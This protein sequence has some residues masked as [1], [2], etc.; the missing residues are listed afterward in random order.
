M[1]CLCQARLPRLLLN[2]GLL[3]LVTVAGGAAARAAEPRGQDHLSSV[4]PSP[5]QSGFGSDATGSWWGARQRLEELGVSI[6][7]ELVLEGFKNFQ[8]GIQTADFVGASTFDL[9]LALDTDKAF[10]WPGGMFYVDLVD[11]AGQNP[12]SVLVGDL[13][14]FD[15][16]NAAPYFEIYSLWYQQRLFDNRLCVTIGKMDA[17]SEFIVNTNGLAFL[18]SSAQLSPT[19]FVLPTYPAPMPGVALFLSP[20]ESFYAGFGAY[21]ANRSVSFGVFSGHPQDAQP[22]RFGGFFVGETGWSWRHAPLLD[23]G[24]DLKLGVWGHTGTFARLEGGEQQGAEGYYVIFDQTLWQPRAA[25]GNEGQSRG[26]RTFLDHGLTGSSV[27]KIDRHFGWGVTWTGP[28]AARPHDIIGLGAEYAHISAQAGLPYP[29]ELSLESLYQIQ[30][31]RWATLMPDLQYI[32]HPGGR[33][34]NALV[35]TLHLTVHF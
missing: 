23:R 21:Y 7:A 33:Y 29:Y 4:P 6:N 22:S 8:G 5:R 24:G 25:P 3:A 14:R 13:Q 19:A 2:A 32:V 1:I 11:H 12:S 20:I 35:G 31:T 30:L 16:L 10:N 27:S 26:V 9:S 15:R 28:A 18:N 34:P 17:N